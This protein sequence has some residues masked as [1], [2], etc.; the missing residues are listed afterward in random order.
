[1]LK[2]SKHKVSTH[3]KGGKAPSAKK[4]EEISS[5]AGEDAPPPMKPVPAKSGR[6]S[7]VKTAAV[8]AVGVPEMWFDSARCPHGRHSEATGTLL[9]DE[10]VECKMVG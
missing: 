5:E 10:I 9:C 4:K 3:K 8:P 2:S 1:M 7:R 6:T